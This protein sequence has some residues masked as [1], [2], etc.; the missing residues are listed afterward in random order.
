MDGG[1]GGYWSPSTS[2]TFSFG[3]HRPKKPKLTDYERELLELAKKKTPSVSGPTVPLVIDMKNGGEPIVRRI[4]NSP[5]LDRMTLAPPDE[6]SA[7]T[8]GSL[9][10]E[11]RAEEQI[12]KVR[13]VID[14]LRNLT[15]SD[16]QL[17]Q[18]ALLVR[19]LERSGI[20]GLVQI[21]G[22]FNGVEHAHGDTGAM[23]SDGTLYGAAERATQGIP[24]AAIITF[25]ADAP[26][27]VA[28][29][30]HEIAHAVQIVTGAGYYRQPT[31]EF[32]PTRI[33][34]E[35]FEASGHGD[36]VSDTYD[37]RDVPNWNRYIPWVT[38]APQHF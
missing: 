2:V 9:G 13:A 30:A 22:E 8:V 3:G 29:L 6:V 26:D 16:G 31:S 7:F 23:N 14:Q 27:S 12:A 35:A 19:K 15:N 11:S 18:G 37:K 10:P 32:E 24:T 17:T 28:T 1:G 20:A 25:D 4:P 5:L 36:R 38:K 21:N 34:N 33:G